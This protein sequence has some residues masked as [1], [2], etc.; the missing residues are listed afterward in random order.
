MPP[1]RYAVRVVDGLQP[2]S[3]RAIAFLECASD[4]AIEAR[5]IF[6]GLSTTKEREVRSRF[7]HWI[8]NGTNDDWFHGFPNDREHKDCFTFKWKENRQCHR[9][10]GFLSNAKPIEEPR[11]Q[12][13]VLAY[14]AIKNTWQTDY[15]ILDR[16][17]RLFQ[18]PDVIRAI[19]TAFQGEETE[20]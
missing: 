8:S 13:C 7:D 14:H 10:Y 5:E 18:N 3:R 4:A 1:I 15:T 9:F 11:F 17:I 6:D 19:I 2:S 20:R 16:C 12:A